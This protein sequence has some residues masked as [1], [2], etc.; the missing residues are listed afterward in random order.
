MPPMVVTLDVSKL[1][2]WLNADATCRVERRAYIWCGTRFGPLVRE[3]AVARAIA[4]GASSAQGR[5]RQDG[6]LGG[7]GAERTENM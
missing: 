2:G 4:V 7:H 5:T 3:S 1:S 6:R